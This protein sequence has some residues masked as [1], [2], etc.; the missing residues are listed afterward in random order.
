MVNHKDQTAMLSGLSGSRAPEPIW[1]YGD[2]IAGGD[3]PADLATG[4]VSLAFVK[5]AIWRGARLWCGMAIMGLLIGLAFYAASPPAHQASTSVLLTLGPYENANSAPMDNQA[6]A[7]SRAVAELAGRKLGLGP[8]AASMLSQYTVAMV[9]PDILKITASAPSAKEAVNRASTVATAFLQFRA[10]QLEAEQNLQLGLANQQISQAQAKLSAISK[11]IS[12]VS[13]QPTSPTQQA[14]LNKLQAERSQSAATLSG[15]QQSASGNR[16]G[17][18]TSLAVK[19]SEVLDSAAP[20]FQSKLKRLFPHP[21]VGFML[22]LALGIGVVV[23]RALSS[24]KLR[25]RDDVAQ[26]LGTPVQLS[27]G[28]VRLSRW[29]PRRHGLAAADTADIRRVVAHLRSALPPGTRRPA[30]LA[31]VPVDDPRAAALSLV[32]LALLCAQEGSQV[33]VADLLSGAPAARLLGA[34]QPGVDR[35]RL[36]DIDLVVAVPEREDVA[37]VGPLGRTAPHAQRPSFS[38]TVAEA[39]ASADL[40]LTLAAVDPSLGADHLPTWATGAVVVVTAGNSSWTQIQA[41]GHM[42]RLA[43]MPPMSAVLVGADKH[44]ESL[45]L[46]DVP[47][48]AAY[49][50][51]GPGGVSR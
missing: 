9:S 21:G 20:V 23:I 44:D 45:G 13:A 18:A 16:A 30:T 38:E 15:L 28:N 4:L 6:I 27:V 50:D 11:Q 43:G 3:R 39:C 2:V 8:N 7:Q 37:P 51:A 34:G 36:H 46:T 42:M 1:T 22:G 41:A 5:A 24:D 25:R 47:G 12:Q 17:A 29:H 49:T 10:A 40:L 31:V 32:S 14:E 35:V 48:S 26:A 33:L 19:H